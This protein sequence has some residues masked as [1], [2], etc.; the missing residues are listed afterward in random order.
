MLTQDLTVRS[1]PGTL[2]LHTI[3]TRPCHGRKIHKNQLIY[4]ERK[5]PRLNERRGFFVSLQEGCS[6]SGCYQGRR[7]GD[8]DLNLGS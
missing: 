2:S 4:S 5:K 1:D 3:L 6:R 7:S 8:D